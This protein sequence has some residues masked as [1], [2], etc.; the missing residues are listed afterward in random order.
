MDTSRI[1][2]DDGGFDGARA[3]GQLE[4]ANRRL[5]ECAVSEVGEIEAALAER[6]EAVRAIAEMEPDEL[7][8]PLAER[9]LRAFEDGRRVRQKLTEFYR[10]ADAELKRLGWIAAAVEA[11]PREPTEISAIG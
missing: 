9:L 2:T 1:P 7:E 5:L 10:N 4:Q 11:L 6:D 8:P 3:V